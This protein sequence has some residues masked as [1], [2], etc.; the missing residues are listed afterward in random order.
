MSQCFSVQV[1]VGFLQTTDE[2]TIANAACLAGRIY[3][4][5]PQPE[6]LA[7]LHPAVAK[8]INA[9]ADQRNCGLPVEIVAAHAE[10]LG[11]LPHPLA[12][13]KY[14]L[15]ASCPYHDYTSPIILTYLLASR[16]TSTLLARRWRLR[17][18]VLWLFRCFLPAWLRFSLP[19][20]LTRKRF[21]APLCVFVFGI[22]E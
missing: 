3:A 18:P 7:L 20:E 22:F 13:A 19:L 11:E 9:G 14:R 2:L 6:K 10:A 5:D 1:D 17:L 4:D 8:G 15:A 21:R 16:P 12:I